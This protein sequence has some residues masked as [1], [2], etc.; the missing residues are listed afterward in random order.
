LREKGGRWGGGKAEDGGREDFGGAEEA[1]EAKGRKI[2][3]GT[4][5]LIRNCRLSK[6]RKT[7]ANIVMEAK[8]KV[9]QS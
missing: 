5:G 8:Q 7:L 9:W 1:G 3:S 2:K 6:K 4:C